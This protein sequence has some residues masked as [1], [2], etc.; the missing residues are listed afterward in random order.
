[1][2][3]FKRSVIAINSSEY[4]NDLMSKANLDFDC[5]EELGMKFNVSSIHLSTSFKHIVS[6]LDDL[7]I[8][9][10]RVSGV[11]KMIKEQEWRRPHRF[12]EQ[13][14][15]VSLHLFNIDWI[16]CHI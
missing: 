7:N 4:E 2:P 13:V 3:Y 6:H 5:C 9:S 15:C 11:E 1:L 12:T 14:F 8:A 10:L 16:V